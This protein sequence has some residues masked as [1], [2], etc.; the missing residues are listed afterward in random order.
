M[1]KLYR[2]MWSLTSL[3]LAAATVSTAALAA[4]NTSTA[5]SELHD[6]SFR[7]EWCDSP[8]HVQA[9]GS[10]TLSCRPRAATIMVADHR[11]DGQTVQIDSTIQ[12]DDGESDEGSQRSSFNALAQL[13]EH[14]RSSELRI[15]ALYLL[16]LAKS[17]AAS[18]ALLGLVQR[19]GSRDDVRQISASV[20]ATQGPRGLVWTRT[21]LAAET[22]D[23]IRVS[24]VEGLLAARDAS[25]IGYLL[26]L[27]AHDHA[28]AVRISAQ[29]VASI[30]LASYF[31]AA[32]SGA[33]NRS[34]SEDA[35]VM[36]RLPEHELADLVRHGK[37]G[38]Q[39]RLALVLLGT[40]PSRIAIVEL[41]SL[42][43]EI[44]TGRLLR[45]TL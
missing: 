38:A 31:D 4:E 37:D 26:D 11:I 39:S 1:Q 28:M 29:R 45:P 25:A 2:V 6:W 43:R 42:D 36:S 7:A 34:Q 44:Q 27:A 10:Y 33:K 18:G 13:A 32:S 21:A 16:A 41:T 23:S 3:I 17:P 15:R 5:V 14:T 9:S 22:P 12:S 30:L 40:R 19:S 20:N 24:L 8:E 35:K